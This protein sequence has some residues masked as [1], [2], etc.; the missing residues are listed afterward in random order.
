MQADDEAFR[1]FVPSV[2][3]YRTIAELASAQCNTI[4]FVVRPLFKLW[5]SLFMTAHVHALT[6]RH[7]LWTNVGAFSRAGLCKRLG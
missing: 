7:L 4:T 5:D 1:G 6:S 3:R 2:P